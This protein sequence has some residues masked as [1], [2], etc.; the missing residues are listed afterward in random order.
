GRFETLLADT[1]TARDA[2]AGPDAHRGHR[3]HRPRTA[4]G[5]D[6]RE[7]S[8]AALARTRP[9]EPARAVAAADSVG[10]GLVP[11]L[12]QAPRGDVA[13]E[14]TERAEQAGPV[15]PDRLA[16]DLSVDLAADDHGDRVPGLAGRRF[17]R[18]GL[19]GADVR[20]RHAVH[21]AVRTGAGAV[22]L[23]ARRARDPQAPRLVPDLSGAERRVLHGVQEPHRACGAA[24]GADR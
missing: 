24:E 4:G 11:G 8:R 14:G 6:R 5:Q 20:A 19:P 9:R 17:L 22:R 13:V 12:A 21:D 3:R 15:V 2:S 23:A 18:C 7:R 16:G 10:T 1:G